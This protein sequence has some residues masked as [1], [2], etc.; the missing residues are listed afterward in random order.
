MG[1]LRENAHV[2]HVSEEMNC[3]EIQGIQR[4]GGEEGLDEQLRE[5]GHRR[6]PGCVGELAEG[7]MILNTGCG[8]E[9]GRHRAKILRFLLSQEPFRGGFHGPVVESVDCPFLT[10]AEH[11][12]RMALVFL[13]LEVYFFVGDQVLLG[14]REREGVTIFIGGSRH[15]C[16]RPSWYR[17]CDVKF[18][19]L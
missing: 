15:G 1:P 17:W 8:A 5:F 11:G 16:C 14:S 7:M 3:E 9:I 12:E 2:I 10:D 19:F 4:R 18:Q 6:L 13:V